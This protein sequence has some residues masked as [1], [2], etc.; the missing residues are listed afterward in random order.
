MNNQTLPGCCICFSYENGFGEIE[1]DLA[2]AK[3]DFLN[4]FQIDMRNEEYIQTRTKK[5]CMKTKKHK[6]KKCF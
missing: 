2:A 4:L 1:K 6:D 5:N 3:I